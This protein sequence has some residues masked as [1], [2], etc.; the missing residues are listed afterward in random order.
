[1]YLVAEH[2]VREE[3]AGRVYDYAQGLFPLLPSRKSVKK[4]LDKGLLKVNGQAV[5]TGYY[6]QVGDVLALWQRPVNQKERELPLEVHYEDE[7]LAVVYKPAGLAVSGYHKHNF[8]QRFRAGLQP[9]LAED[10]LP[11]P[12][13]VHRLDLPTQGLLLVGKRAS[14]LRFLQAAFAQRSIQKTYL[15][16]VMGRP[17]QA[18][19]R[20]DSPVDG[21][22]AETNY[23][24][25]WSVP[26]L[27]SGQLSLLEL[28]PKTGRKH[29]LRQQLAQMGCPIVGDKQY[30]PKGKTLLHKG[31][32]LA[33]VGLAF[34][35]PAGGQI[36]LSMPAPS[37]FLRLLERERRQWEKYQPLV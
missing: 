5:G 4:A 17:A 6:L 21:K 35:H 13:P 34:D 15:A 24:L 14:S 7:D 26:S 12:L 3:R 29:Q 11:S 16:I 20:L 31:L 9:S 23:R 8:Q 18:K 30:G 19:G 28:Q 25:L 27:R 37:K 2:Q 10:A 22:A 36:E 33:A 32:F 1:M